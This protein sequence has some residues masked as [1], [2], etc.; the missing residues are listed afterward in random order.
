MLQYTIDQNVKMTSPITFT[1]FGSR[2]KFESL[3][4]LHKVVYGA[5]G[6]TANLYQPEEIRRKDF[7][8]SEDLS[9]K[10]MIYLRDTNKTYG[11]QKDLLSEYIVE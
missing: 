5:G 9:G 1:V 2:Y 4:M 11:L 10:I 7:H 6:L 8:V 3:D